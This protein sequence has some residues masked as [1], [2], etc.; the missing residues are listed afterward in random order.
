MI[1]SH[2]LKFI[3]ILALIVLLSHCD[4]LG[5]VATILILLA[6]LWKLTA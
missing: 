3:G 1:F 2:I 5:A 4:P 6:G